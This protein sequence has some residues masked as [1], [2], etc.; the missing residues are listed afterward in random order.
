MAINPN[1]EL[2]A[3]HALFIGQTGSGKSWRMA[4]HP[5]V[6][7][8]RGNRVIMWDPYETHDA[9]YIRSKA[10][11][12]R[13]VARAVRSGK[14]FRLALAVD[15]TPAAFEFWANV[16]WAALDG[17]KPTAL[18]VEELADVAKPG[19]A[20]PAWGK[21]IRV[22]RKFGGVVIAGT[23]RPQEIDK[24][25]FTQCQRKW[26][27]WVDDYDQPYCERNLGLE[28]GALARIAPESYAFWYVNG[29][30]KMHGT[31]KTALPDL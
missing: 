21:C 8:R 23:Q 2:K 15:A 16:A 27:G 26:C 28:K 22:G 10:T 11:F 17:N 13:E 12:A 4:R 24:T 31:A 7:R 18:M 9:H 5:L 19:K 25:L 29:N 14:G 3:R 6:K 1:E 30:R 20:G